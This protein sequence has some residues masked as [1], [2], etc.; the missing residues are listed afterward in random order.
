MFPYDMRASPSQRFG[1]FNVVL[2]FEHENL[3]SHQPTDAH[4]AEDYEYHECE[5]DAS[6]CFLQECVAIESSDQ[7][8]VAEDVHGK[9][10]Q[11]QHE[12]GGAHEYGVDYAAEITGYQP[13]QCAY[14]DGDDRGNYSQ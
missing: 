3:A 12:V 5:R 2:A 1:G 7:N 14:E 11:R 9:D 8:P 6:L 10:G 13:E 4:P